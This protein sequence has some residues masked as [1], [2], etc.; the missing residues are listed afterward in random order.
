MKSTPYNI[1]YLLIFF[2][3]TLSCEKENILLPV[4][5]E[6]PIIYQ[7]C[8]LKEGSSA[9]IKTQAGLDTI[10]NETCISSTYVLQN[11]DFTKYDLLVGADSYTRGIMK[12]E[13]SFYKNNPNEY[14][15]SVTVYYDLTLPAGTFFYGIIVNKIPL[16][17]KVNF[18]VK[19]INE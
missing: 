19:R 1:F 15:Y 8:T 10:F 14:I 7:G 16:D 4:E 9:V 18:V 2:T 17:S 11:I 12:L 6:L 5:A 13:H 3:L